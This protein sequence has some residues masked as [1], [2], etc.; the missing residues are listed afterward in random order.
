MSEDSEYKVFDVR[1][2]DALEIEGV[3]YCGLVTKDARQVAGGYKRGVKRLEKDQEEFDNFLRRVIE[4]TLHKEPE[5]T[6]GELNYVCARRDHVVLISFPFPVS[7]HILLVSAEPQVNI[8]ELAKQISRIF[9][10]STI[11]SEWDMK[12]N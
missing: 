1:C 9:G 6:L 4:I 8:E 11:F 10:D 7:D 2:N 12:E 3:R 5:E